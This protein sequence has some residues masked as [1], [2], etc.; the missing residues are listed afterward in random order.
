MSGPVLDFT[1]ALYL[2]LRH[3]SGSLRAW[4]QLTLGKPAAMEAPP[5]AAD[6]ASGLAALIGCRRAVLAPSTLH[7]F[8]DL[9]GILGDAGARLFLD[10][11]AYPIAK[12]GVERAAARG[13]PVRTVPRHDPRALAALLA[14]GAG[15]R[16][17]P[18]FIADGYC[19]ACGRRAPVREFLEC[20]KPYGGLLVLDDTQAFGILGESPRAAAPYGSGGGGSLRFHGA[21]DAGVLIVS[22]MAKGFGVPV[23]VLAGGERMISQFEERSATRVHC[24]PPSVAVIR[25][26][27]HALAVN[28]R[29]G[30]AL[31]L[32]LAGLVSRFRRGLARAA[33]AAS[34][35]LFPIQ[36]LRTPPDFDVI[37]FHERLRA[38]NINAVLHRDRRG[39]GSRIS[40]IVTARHTAGA[41]DRALQVVGRLAREMNHAHA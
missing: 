7:L 28:R 41:I 6:V 35:G 30:D 19:P 16:G 1:S 26:A 5:G 21:P 27:A 40:F 29:C 4:D 24:S 14:S 34:G 38:A 12:W 18:V 9:F 15:G 23:A 10:A 22:S 31:R 8:W 36:T 2:G 13:T 20:L 32:R 25:A 37:G 39:A 11:G 3:S 17:L 33:L